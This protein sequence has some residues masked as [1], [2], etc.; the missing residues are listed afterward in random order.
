MMPLEKAFCSISE[1]MRSHHPLVHHITNYVTAGFCADAALA[2]GASP[3]MADEEGEMP[4]IS[5]LSDALVL[6]LGTMNERTY[7]A[8]KKA[9]VGTAACGRPILLDPVGVMSSSFRFDAARTLLQTGAITVIKGNSAEGKALLSWQG[10]GGKGVDSLSDDH[11]ERIAKAL[12]C[13]FHCTAAVTGATDAVSDGIV[14]YLAHNGTAYL[15]RITGAGCMTGTLMAA[16]LG[17]YPESPLYAALWGLTVMNTGA[18]LAEKDVPGPGTF[19][20]HL[21]DA[22]SQHE[23]HRLYNLFKGG[24]AK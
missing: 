4:A 18:E 6:N 8:M 7:G 12:A 11:P 1:A 22:I 20:A 5:Q 9:L 21:M 2:I 3:M 17:V 19:R 10:E 13:K 14:T 23:G 15:G 16:A 24:P